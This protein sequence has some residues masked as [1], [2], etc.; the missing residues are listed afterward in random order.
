MWFVKFLFKFL[1]TITGTVRPWLYLK[2]RISVFQHTSE[3]L[4]VDSDHTLCDCCTTSWHF[5]STSVTRAWR[6][7]FTPAQRPKKQPGKHLKVWYHPP[8]DLMEPAPSL[9]SNI[10]R[11]FSPSGM[12]YPFFPGMPIPAGI[13]TK[14]EWLSFIWKMTEQDRQLSG[15]RTTMRELSLSSDVAFIAICG[16]SRT[17]S[18][19]SK[20]TKQAVSWYKKKDLKK[21]AELHCFF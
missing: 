8:Q 10:T 9:K 17:C 4:V 16:R 1:R 19:T 13:F 2:K 18:C 14:S 11:F 15:R 5:D 7:F 21:Q 12:L 20:E 6:F 3:V